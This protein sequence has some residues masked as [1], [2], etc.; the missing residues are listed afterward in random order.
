MDSSLKFR[1]KPISP[2]KNSKRNALSHQAFPPKS[3]DSFSKVRYRI[4]KV[5]RKNLEG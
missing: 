3:R 5:I 1:F 2:S 4:Y